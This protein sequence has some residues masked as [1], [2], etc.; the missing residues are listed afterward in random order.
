MS[1]GINNRNLSKQFMEN[2]KSISVVISTYNHADFI[3]KTL[4]SILNQSLAP[5]RYEI[6]V[7]NDGC[8]DHTP[9]V[10][11]KYAK[12]IRVVD[13]GRNRGVVYSCNQAIAQARG[14]YFIRV[15]SDDT[16]DTN[17][18]LCKSA[19]LDSNADIG[20]V[21]SDRFEVDCRNNT[22][23]RVNLERFELFKTVACG[24]MFRTDYLRK[25]GGYD[26]LF[27]EEYDLLI[28]YMNKY[29][30]YHIKIPF[31]YYRF[32]GGNTM[33]DKDKID[34]GKKELIAKWGEGELKKWG[35]REDLFSAL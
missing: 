8:T 15:D 23:N 5:S 16:I 25:I 11:A 24:I 29:N 9:Q 12:S 22:K 13:N 33:L 31:Y 32:H 4:D 17:T 1:N 20:F 30:G 18:L 27:F 19:V 3:N 26:N 14:E 10:L 7:V 21:Y 2:Q 35:Y 28:R 34:T 6:I